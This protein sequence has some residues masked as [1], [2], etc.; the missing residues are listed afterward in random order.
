TKVL[1]L[2][3]NLGSCLVKIDKMRYRCLIDSGADSCLISARMYKNLPNRLKLKSGGPSL[4]TASGETLNILGQ[5][6][7]PFTM[8]GL[9]M[10]HKFYVT[11]GLFRNMLLGRDWM[12][13]Y[14]LKINSEKVPV[15]ITNKTNKFYNLRRGSVV[16]R[17]TVIGTEDICTV[18]NEKTDQGIG[19]IEKEVKV[20]R[21]HRKQVLGVIRK[22]KDLFAKKDTEL[23]QTST[24][25]MKIDTGDHPPIKMRP[26]RVP[27]H[28]RKIIE[29]AI[30]DMLEAKVIERSRSPWAF[31]LVVVKKKDGSDRMC[32]DFRA[33]NKIVRP[34]SF[35]LPLIDDIIASLS[36]AQHFTTL[37]L[38]SGYWQVKLEE[39]SKEKTAFSCH[40]GLYQFKVMPFGLHNAAPIFQELMNRVLEECRSFAIAYLDDILIYSKTPEE[41]IKHIQTVFD[42]LRENNLRLKLKKCTFFEQETEYLGFLISNKGVKPNPKKVEAIKEMPP[43]KNVREV[44][45]FIGV[46]SYYRRFIPNFSTIA[47]PLIKLTRKYA[48]FKWTADCT[49]AFE[50]L[51]DSLTVVPLLVY[52]NLNKPFVLYTDASDTCIGACLSQETDEGEEQPIYF[53]SHKLSP[54]QVKWSTIEKEGFA[55]HYSLQKLDHYLHGAKFVIK[56]DHKPL[57][58]ILDSPMQN[59]KIQRW[60]LT[61]AGYDCRIDYISGKENHCADLL[62]RS[63]ATHEK[64]TPESD[65]EEPNIDD[66]SFQ[67][68]VIN[69]N[70]FEPKDYAKCS[71]GPPGE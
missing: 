5:I 42:K 21:E 44:R 24:V 53:L 25:T 45:G 61:I 13:K 36:E 57:K 71:M 51:K 63:P 48:R 14:G 22:N 23:G 46:C 27:L 70:E 35:P 18:I 16:G 59:K 4:K 12:K 49:K 56:T 19:D 37:D 68:N 10:S 62:S 6:E 43:P 17:C 2:A 1:N 50:Y 38:K 20:P 33:L 39:D 7:L 15:M 30:D 29:S 60:A 65:I 32:V 11:E 69:S 55:I 54:S 64:S 41:H 58:Y 8:N 34:I 26:Y 3:G 67:V 47:E 52:P 31:S 66:R 9:Q 28:K 40:K